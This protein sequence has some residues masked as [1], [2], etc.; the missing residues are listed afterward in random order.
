MQIDELMRLCAEKHR[1]WCPE[2]L[3]W[4]IHGYCWLDIV[5]NDVLD[6]HARAAFLWHWQQRMDEDDMNTIATKWSREKNRLVT[7]WVAESPE[8][9]PVLHE[10]PNRNSALVAYV[11]S[12]IGASDAR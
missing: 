6:R 1:E 4:C 12:Q 10:H 2:G 9:Y 11:A 3:T 8:E 7:V 5:A